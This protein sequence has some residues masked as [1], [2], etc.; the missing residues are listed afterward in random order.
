M[1]RYQ[2]RVCLHVAAQHGHVDLALSLLRQ[3]VRA[4]EPVGDH[5][6]RCVHEGSIVIVL[7]Y[8]N[9][10]AKDIENPGLAYQ[11]QLMLIYQSIWLIAAITGLPGFLILTDFYGFYGYIS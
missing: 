2:M 11:H 10:A 8:C 5:P 6:A 1:F 7:Y 9:R 4:D 3:G